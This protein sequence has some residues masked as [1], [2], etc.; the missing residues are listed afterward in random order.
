MQA[1]HRWH[2]QAPSLDENRR[3]DAVNRMRIKLTNSQVRALKELSV[4]ENKSMAELIREAVDAFLCSGLLVDREAVKRRAIA[5]AGE[6]HSGLSD[7]SANH[8]G[9]LREA[10]AGDDAR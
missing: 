5:A 2:N 6:F 3:E 10:Y 1:W 8:D 7:L 4:A 9:Y